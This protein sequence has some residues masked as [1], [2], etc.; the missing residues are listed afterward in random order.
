M[1]KLV[2][3]MNNGNEYHIEENESFDRRYNL[4]VSQLMIRIN[5]YIGKGLKVIFIPSDGRNITFVSRSGIIKLETASIAVRYIAS[6]DL[7]E[8]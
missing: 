8:E 1:K 3:R 7:V 6:I 2:I 5:N 4:S